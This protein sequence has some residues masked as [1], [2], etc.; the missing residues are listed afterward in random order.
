M[1]AIR[2]PK[3]FTYLLVVSVGLI[4]VG[5]FDFSGRGS[6]VTCGYAS[7]SR[8]ITSLLGF[9]YRITAVGFGRIGYYNGCGFTQ[10]S[11]VRMMIETFGTLSF[12]I[13][14]SYPA[15]KPLEG[16]HTRLSTVLVVIGSLGILLAW[17]NEYLPGFLLIVILG[18]TAVMR[19][20]WA[21]MR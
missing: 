10:I 6:G 7:I 11:T 16:I 3:T 18:F 14:V 8:W 9:D 5:L 15:A 1:V 12:M 2:S 17:Y 19:S 21:K 4:V 20:K 13:L